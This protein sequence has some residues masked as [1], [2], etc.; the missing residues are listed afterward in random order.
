MKIQCTDRKTFEL[1][2]ESE[3]LGQISYEGLFTFKAQALVGDD[4]YEITPIG[5]FSTTIAVTHRGREI[6]TMAMSWKGYIVISFR[7][8]EEYRLKATGPFLNKYVLED[9]HHQKLM[10]LDPDFEW[11]K[12]SYK[13]SISYEDKPEDILLVLLATYAAIF[14]MAGSSGEG[15]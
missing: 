15:Y 2:D 13:F 12:F 3:K 11:A 5:F 4:H 9:K 10:L 14:F 6:A 1:K 8:G 7:N